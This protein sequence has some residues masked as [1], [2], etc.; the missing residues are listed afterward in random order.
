MK[1][2]IKYPI[3]EVKTQ[4]GHAIANRIRDRLGDRHDAQGRK[5]KWSPA[6]AL[7]LLQ[8]IELCRELGESVRG[9]LHAASVGYRTYW[10]FAR[11]LTLG[12]VPMPW[13]PLRELMSRAGIVAVP[14]ADPPVQVFEVI[15]R[16]K[17]TVVR[18]QV[19]HFVDLERV[20]KSEMK[21][22]LE[23]AGIECN[24]DGCPIMRSPKGRKLL[25]PLG[26]ERFS[27]LL[28][29]STG[30]LKKQLEAVGK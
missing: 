14:I 2:P 5:A 28:A 6:A 23:L 29:E 27:R 12:A 30:A 15:E 20:R 8:Q 22:H 21:A 18:A 11:G 10:V 26:S 13:M 17:P 1:K 9:V 24:D 4:D 3:P 25:A 19:S 7:F 16:G